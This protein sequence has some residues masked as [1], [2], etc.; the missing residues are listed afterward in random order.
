M[1]V[2]FNRRIDSRTL[3]H[4]HSIGI[5]YMSKCLLSTSLHESGLLSIAHAKD[6][7]PIYKSAV[8]NSITPCWNPGNEAEQ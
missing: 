5:I 1:L 8:K 7:F 4:L 6:R 2:F 3:A